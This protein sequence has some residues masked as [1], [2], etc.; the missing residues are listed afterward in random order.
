MSFQPAFLDFKRGIRVGHLES[1]ERIT[2][3]LKTRLE[4]VTG[5][6]FNIDRFG[7]GVYWQWI[8]FCPRRNRT[9]KTES[10]SRNFCSAKFFI[11]VEID[12]QLFTVGAQVERGFLSPPPQWKAA[13]LAPDWDW[14]RLLANL[15]KPV[16][17]EVLER[18]VREESFQLRTGS[19]EHAQ[20]FDS[21]NFPNRQ[22]LIDAL[23]DAPDDEWSALQ[24]YFAI[25]RE[26]VEASSGPDLVDAMMAVFL[27]VI[28]VM[29]G[30]MQI[31]LKGTSECTRHL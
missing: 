3:I 2:Q 17:F 25:S 19:W 30:A 7:R 11:S 6:I 23:Q 22:Q 13:R 21:S 29:N 27:E 1:S 26:E 16:F 31:A 4:Q 28:P 24:V 8:C 12:Q 9:L 15:R 18:L 5:E 14:H 20:R 10:G